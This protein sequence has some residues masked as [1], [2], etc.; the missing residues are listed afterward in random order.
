M[1]NTKLYL[2]DLISMCLNKNNISYC[3]LNTSIEYPDIAL[4]KFWN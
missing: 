1:S 2:V 3:R 4:E